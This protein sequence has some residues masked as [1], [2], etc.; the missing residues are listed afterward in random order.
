[1]LTLAHVISVVN[2]NS[3]GKQCY[4][5]MQSL[6]LLNYCA[7]KVVISGF[8]KVLEL[9]IVYGAATKDLTHCNLISLY[10]YQ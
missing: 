9:Q 3:K 4:K 8:M 5:L 10:I 1:M 6:N 7:V 2:E